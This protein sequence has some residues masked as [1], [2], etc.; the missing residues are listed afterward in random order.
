MEKP[1]S[2]WS[3]EV[4]VLMPQRPRSGRGLA[5]VEPIGPALQALLDEGR[6]ESVFQAGRQVSAATPVLPKVYTVKTLGEAQTRDVLETLADD[7]STAVVYVAP[8]RGVLGRSPGA[9]MGTQ[10]PGM[11]HWGMQYV[12][13][14]TDPVDASA[15][16]I[17]VVDTGVDRHHPDLVNAIDDYVNFCLGESD[18]DLQGHGTH[19]CGII[20]AT[21][22]APTGMKGACN[23]RLRVFKGMGVK[24]SATDYYRALGAA[25]EGARIVNLSLGGPDHDP[26]EDLIIQQGLN[27]GSLVIAASGNDG[28]DGSYPNY[29]ARLPGVLAVGAINEQG[30]RAAFS[31][32]GPHLSL[33]APGVDIWSTV[34]MKA[35]SLFKKRTQYAPCSGTSMA[36]PFVSAMAARV[37]A[38]HPDPS[39]AA[40]IRDNIPVERCP[41]QTGK[42]DDLGY[43]CVH[44][45][46]PL[47]LSNA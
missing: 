14:D 11:S 24:Y 46:G 45:K 7:M 47:V 2:A 30:V 9:N 25:I 6:A 40:T 3:H 38:A 43:G 35:S 19:V 12:A 16:A 36:T 17:A 22:Q 23:A 8:P 33:V 28:D 15:I 26:A 20:A 41:G 27:G 21:G 10:S 4:V 42:T 13:A 32:A 31:N 18:D 39:P 1:V 34:P 44:W 5:A 29:P 37:A